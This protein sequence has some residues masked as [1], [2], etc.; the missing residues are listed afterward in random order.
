[1]RTCSCSSGYMHIWLH[2]AL[3]RTFEAFW[4]IGILRS[5]GA[6]SERV[7]KDSDVHRGQSSEG[8][9]GAEPARLS[10]VERGHRDESR[11]GTQECVRHVRLTIVGHG[12]SYGNTGFTIIPSLI[13]LADGSATAS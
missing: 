4:P 3:G 13:G 1:M 9:V 12:P 8:W 6:E 10:L 7:P 2:I 11:R 5:L